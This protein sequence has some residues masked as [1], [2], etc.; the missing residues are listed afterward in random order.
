MLFATLGKGLINALI[1]KVALVPLPQDSTQHKAGRE[2]LR[3]I[4]VRL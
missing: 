2:S 4:I 3:G 1:G